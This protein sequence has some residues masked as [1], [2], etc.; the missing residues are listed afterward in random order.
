MN[1]IQ[2]EMVGQMF[3]FSQAFFFPFKINEKYTKFRDKN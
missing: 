3:F 1:P 2:L